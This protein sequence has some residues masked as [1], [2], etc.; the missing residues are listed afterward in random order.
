[1]RL[2]SASRIFGAL[3]AAVLVAGCT[4]TVERNDTP[5]AVIVVSGTGTLTVDW[6]INGTKDPN[7]CSQGT[8]AAIEIVITD[9]HGVSAGTYQQSCT[10]FATSIELD[11]GY[12]SASAR[13]VDSAGRDRTTAVQ[14]T[15]FAIRGGD[16][17]DTPVDFGAES[18][19]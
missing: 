16:D 13:L 2:P 11:A 15:G 12:Y 5:P 3:A 19:Y 7:Q 14:I 4:A 18:F 17:L 8:A 6:S 10:A 1:M 9:S